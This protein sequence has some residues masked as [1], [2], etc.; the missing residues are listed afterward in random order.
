[1][2]IYTKSGDQGET[3]LVEGTRVAKNHPR[4]EAYGTVDELNSQL[5]ICLSLISK[6]HE[7]SSTAQFIVKI[8]NS[9][10][11][12]GSRLACENKEMKVKLPS[13]EESD[14]EALEKQIDTM[15]SELPLL[16]EFILPGGHP[17]AAHMHVARTICRR[18][19]RRAVGLEKAEVDKNTSVKYLNRL[20]DYLFVCARFLNF[21]MKVSETTWSK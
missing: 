1:M 10:F 17:M 4:V 21:K 19:E 7:L 5:G 13:I 12:L 18:A 6:E 16:K 8:Q 3:S 2:K 20:S 11:N 15:N 14:I 9:L